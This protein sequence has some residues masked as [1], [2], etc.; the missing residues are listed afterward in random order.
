MRAGASELQFVVGDT[1]DQQPV[2]FDMRIAP[3][4]PVPAQWMVEIAG[5]DR[6]LFDQLQKQRAKLGH[7][8]AALLGP[9]HVALE[10]AGTDR[11]QHIQM[12]RSLNRASASA[13]VLPLPLSISSTALRVVAFGT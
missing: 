9:F 7:V 11:G 13:S 4:F 8:L 1:I 10:L 3:T 12:P 2:G 5:G 6:A